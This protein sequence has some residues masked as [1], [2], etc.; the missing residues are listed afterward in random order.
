MLAPAEQLLLAQVGV[1]NGGF[2]L[3]VAGEVYARPALH[4]WIRCIGPLVLDTVDG[5]SSLVDKNLLLQTEGRDGEARFMMLETIREYALDRLDASGE[6]QIVRRRHAETFLRLA[7]IAEPHLRRAEQVGWISWLDREHDN[8]R[9]ALAW[10][11]EEEGD[12][13]LALRLVNAL[14]HFWYLRAH[15]R[16]GSRWQDAALAKAGENAP[17]HLHAWALGYGTLL[18][19]GADDFPHGR[20]LGE[21]AL[22]LA[23]TLDDSRLVAYV[24]MPLSSHRKIQ[25]EVEEAKMLL[26]EGLDAARAVDDHWAITCVLNALL[27]ENADPAQGLPSV[28]SNL[29]LARQSETVR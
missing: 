17:A 7:E 20:R 21:A 27:I 23:R 3:E 2:T 14:S 16:E 28:E 8:L 1:F 29:A 19:L 12:A 5:L 18:A 6:S 25:G 4:R 11:L 13:L 24:A 10:S 26:M 15:Y 9:A 22:T